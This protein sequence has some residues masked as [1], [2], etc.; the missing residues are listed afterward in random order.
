MLNK[1]RDLTV[2]AGNGTLNKTAKD[3][4]ATQL[5]GLNQDL[6]SDREHQAPRAQHLCRQLRCGDRLRPG[7]PLGL[8]RGCHSSVERR[9][10][11]DQTIRV[12]ADGA[13]I[14]GDGDSSVFNLVSDMA[15]LCG[16]ARISLRS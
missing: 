10:S 12:D 7:G 13:K 14:F 6:L 4:I 15:A 16:L 5:D 8:Q 9:I 1:I 3:A 11:A 2:Q